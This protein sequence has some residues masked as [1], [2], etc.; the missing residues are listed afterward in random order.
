[1]RAFNYPTLRGWA[2]GGRTD[3]A[4]PRTSFLRK[5]GLANFLVH[6]RKALQQYLMCIFVNGSRRNDIQSVLL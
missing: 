6:L 1:M 2:R 4:S 5:I 3:V